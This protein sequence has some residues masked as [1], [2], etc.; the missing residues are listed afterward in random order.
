MD[1]ETRALHLVTHHGLW[2]KQLWAYP[3]GGDTSDPL[4]GVSV[5][6]NVCLY[7]TD[8]GSVFVFHVSF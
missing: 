6:D 1:F 3:G 4:R 7:C 5:L 8:S 2:A